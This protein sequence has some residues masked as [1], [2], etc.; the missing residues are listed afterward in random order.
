VERRRR[1]L[2]TSAGPAGH[3]Y[4]LAASRPYG[5]PHTV[6][7]FARGPHRLGLARGADEAERSTALAFPWMPD[8]PPPGPID[9]ALLKGSGT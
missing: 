9:A 7:V 8:N 2:T 4:R 1:E 3:T 6:H 5:I